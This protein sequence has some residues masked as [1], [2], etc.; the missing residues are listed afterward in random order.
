MHGIDISKLYIGFTRAAEAE[1]FRRSAPE[2]RTLRDRQTITVATDVGAASQPLKK[3]YFTTANQ[4]NRTIRSQDP[5]I[6]DGSGISRDLMLGI[7]GVALRFNHGEYATLDDTR[8][9]LTALGDAVLEVRI[10]SEVLCELSGYECLVGSPGFESTTDAAAA[11]DA[12]TSIDKRA[13]PFTLEWARVLREGA[14]LGAD[15][16]VNKT[17]WTTA[18]NFDVFLEIDCWVARAGSPVAA[19]AHVAPYIS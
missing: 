8:E 6:L 13:E 5:K 14:Q 9:V 19:A 7:F 2:R 10:G 4:P 16:F 15:L 11:T 3:S 12:R 1:G 18:V 17:S